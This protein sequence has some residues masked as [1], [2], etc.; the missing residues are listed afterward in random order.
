MRSALTARRQRPRSRGDKRAPCEK[1][2]TH[3]MAIR[4]GK[5]AFLQANCAKKANFIRKALLC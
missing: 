1:I 2:S 5:Q 3:R 4:E